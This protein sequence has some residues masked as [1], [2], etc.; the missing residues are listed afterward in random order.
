LVILKSII[1]TNTTPNKMKKLPAA[2]S[3]PLIAFFGFG[4]VTGRGKK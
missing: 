3:P 2:L 1:Y 4:P